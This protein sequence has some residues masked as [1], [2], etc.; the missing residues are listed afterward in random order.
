MMGAGAFILLKA[1]RGA[2]E[3]VKRVEIRLAKMLT[4]LAIADSE[5]RNL[6]A[7]G[8]WHMRWLWLWRFPQDMAN[9]SGFRHYIF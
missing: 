3:S 7:T 5:R 8:R 6:L 9:G 2:P 1:G 4:I